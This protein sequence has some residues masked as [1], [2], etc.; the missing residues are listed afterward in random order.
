MP[1]GLMVYIVLCSELYDR[2]GSPYGDPSGA[3]WI[4]NDV[5]FARLGL[6]A[7]EIAAGLGDL[8]WKPDLLHLNDWPSALAPAFS[9]GAAS[10]RRRF[11]RFTT[12]LTRASSG[13]SV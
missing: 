12:S 1:D 5:R 2:E 3:D 6:A 13:P 11:S 8:D 4:D 7:A 10:P 9:P